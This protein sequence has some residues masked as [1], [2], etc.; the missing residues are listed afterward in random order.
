MLVVVILGF[1]AVGEVTAGNDTD[2]V[3]QATCFPT[4][5]V[6]VKLLSKIELPAQHINDFCAVLKVLC[7]DYCEKTSKHI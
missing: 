1:M 5:P 7:I 2:V 4:K 6:C 3:C